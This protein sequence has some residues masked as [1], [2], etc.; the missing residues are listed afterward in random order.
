MSLSAEQ[1][2]QKFKML[3]SQ[4]KFDFSVADKEISAAFLAAISDSQTNPIVSEKIVLPQKEAPIQML[5][6]KSGKGLWVSG[7]TYSYKD[8]FKALGGSWNKSKQS[9]VFSLTK[10]QELLDLLKLKEE[11]IGVEP[12]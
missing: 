10:Q 2:L 5:K 8:Q 9:W 4:T 11:D 3:L 1:K 12:Q 7:K 6:T